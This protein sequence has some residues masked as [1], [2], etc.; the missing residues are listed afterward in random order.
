VST[1]TTM[2]IPIRQDNNT[3]NIFCLLF[4]NSFS[5]LIKSNN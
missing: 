5:F 1:A 4:Q 3:C 2:S